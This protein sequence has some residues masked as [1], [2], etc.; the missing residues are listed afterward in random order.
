MGS[1]GDDTMRRG[2]RA[3]LPPAAVSLL[4]LGLL[5]WPS[6]AP[7]TPLR[8]SSPLPSRRPWKEDQQCRQFNISYLEP[9]SGDICPLASY[10]GSGSTW[11]RYLIE[12]ATGVFTG[13]IYKDLQLQVMGYW[14]E[15]RHWRDGT[16]IV[17]KTHDG[18]AQYIREVFNGRGILILRNPYDAV[19]SKLNFLYGGHRGASSVKLF[20]RAEWEEFVKVE[21]NDWV[22]L[23]LNWTLPAAAT[24]DKL[25][26]VHYEH[27]R[28]DPI[29]EVKK[30]LKFLKIE[31]D[32][33]RLNCLLKFKNGY[34]KRKSKPKLSEI[35]FSRSQRS[36]IDKIIR[37]VNEVLVRKGYQNLPT[38]FYNYYEKT[39]R[40]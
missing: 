27:F 32:P 30:I 24:A 33:E 36:A 13:S 16:T 15:I 23:A 34:F 28:N 19:L 4:L 8:L 18:D 14:G 37:N 25:L 21:L 2:L 31:E 20:Q 35:P 5:S 3:L 7:V 11:V 17:Q 39:E 12:G 9:K 6:E 40:E 29:A 38:E 10:P 26:V 1:R 22:S